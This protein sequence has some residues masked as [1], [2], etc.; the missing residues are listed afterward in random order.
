[1]RAAYTPGMAT[2]LGTLPAWLERLREDSRGPLSSAERA[3]RRA[4][5]RRALAHR[6]ALPSI[7]PDTTGDYIHE[8]REEA[9][10]RP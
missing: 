2:R 9:G 3:R 5:T 6:D 4:A 7:A 1:M 10:S 8:V